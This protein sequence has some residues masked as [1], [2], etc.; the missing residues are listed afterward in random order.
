VTDIAPTIYDVVGITPPA[1]VNGVEQLP[2]E[3]KSLAASFTDGETPST[4]PVQYF[5][6]VGN[7]GIYKDGWWAG[8][9]HLLPWQREAWDKAE[10]GQHPW[11]LYNLNED[12]SQAHDLAAKYPEKL[13]ELTALFDS[14]ARRNNV[15][16]LAPY[17]ASRPPSSANGR[18]HFVF[19]SGVERVPLRSAPNPRGRSHSLTADI[20][21]PATGADGVIIAEGGRSSGFSLYVKDEKPV[22]EVTSFGHEVIRITASEPL[23]AGK[24]SRIVVDVTND[25]AGQPSAKVRLSFNGKLAGEGVLNQFVAAYGETLDVG[26]DLG[27]PISPAYE[28]PF[29]F[30]GAIETV[31]LDLK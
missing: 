8:A 31:V 13:K 12:Y 23:S 15:Y 9:R 24:K 14:E 22:Y 4:H 29:A 10:I 11:E 30:T 28:S 16:P 1:T 18:D 21:V 2:L 7:R 3:G 19:R 6:M 25:Q 27:T 26:K 17:T 5:E 20:E